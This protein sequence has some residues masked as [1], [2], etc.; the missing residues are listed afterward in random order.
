MPSFPDF[1]RYD[2]TGMAELVRRREVEPRELLEEAISRT[3]A[4][5]PLINAVITRMYEHGRRRLAGPPVTGVFGGV[6][7]LLKDLLQSYAGFPL[8][9]G[10]EALRDY[11]PKWDSEVVRRFKRAGLIAFGKTNVPEFGLVATTEPEA[12]GPTLNPWNPARS[13]GGSSGGSAA[14]VAAGL[15]PIA[16]AND[17]GGSIRIPAAWC[18]LFG[19]KPSRGRVPVG[20]YH[21]EIW[22]G[23][24]ADHVLTKS[25]RDSAAMLDAIIGPAPGDPYHYERPER[26]FVEEAAIDPD[27]LR[28]AFTTRSPIGSTVDPEC[29]RAVE[30]TARLL[31][32]LGHQVEE[33]LPP[34]NGVEVARAYLFLYYG[35]VGAEL[36]WVAE[37]FGAGAA[38]KRVEAATRA[39]ATI[40]ESISAAEFLESRQRWNEFA[41][42]MGAFHQ[43]YDLFMTPTTA[44][45]PVELGS[46]SMSPLEKAALRVA[47]RTGAGRAMRASGIPE[48]LA[49]QNLG[50]VPFTQLANLTG[51]PAMSVPLH[52]SESGLPCGVHFMA[53]VAC[54]AVLFRLAGQLEKARP[55]RDRT[56]PIRARSE[57]SAV[58]SAR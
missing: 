46:L 53:P 28:I 26:P 38:R 34:I 31:E 6:P 45:L 3:E 13:P 32:D 18:G 17:G 40:G 47:N 37:T 50:P 57:P 43:R 8:S 48:R 23:A 51:Q 41:R 33:A 39:V 4:V 16:S 5:N 12:F 27:P 49:L 15:V 11:V 29:R 19:L 22:G 7:F 36:R 58:A 44:S 25:V 35:Y 14:A 10:S 42:V 2:A 55:W 1:D 20:P 9:C 54:E 56:P 21:A 24:V 52:W 30:E